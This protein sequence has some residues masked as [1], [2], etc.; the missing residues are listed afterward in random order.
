MVAAFLSLLIWLIIFAVIFG[1][2]Y[3]ALGLLSIPEPI[4]KIVLLVVGAIGL[5]ILLQKMIPLLAHL[6]MIVRT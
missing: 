2:I 4:R 5:I 6:G 1:V 3:Y